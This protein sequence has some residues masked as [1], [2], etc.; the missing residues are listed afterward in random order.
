M[1][2][3]AFS[4]KAPDYVSQILLERKQPYLYG[5][6]WVM[7][8]YADLK[9]DR[10]VLESSICGARKECSRLVRKSDNTLFEPVQE[11]VDGLKKLGVQIE[12]Q[13]LKKNWTLTLRVDDSAGGAPLLG[14]L[15]T[16]V[17]SLVQQ[18]GEPLY[19]NGYNLK[20]QAFKAFSQ[21]DMSSL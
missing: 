17:F 8:L 21:V 1:L 13:P 15:K 4:Q 6:M 9:G 2:A 5:I 18:Y 14:S 7:G 20:G 12:F 3:K 10:L 11:V 16:Y 19:V